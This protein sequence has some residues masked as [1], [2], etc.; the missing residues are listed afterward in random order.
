MSLL[1]PRFNHSNITCKWVGGR[2]FTG[3][4]PHDAVPGVEGDVLGLMTDLS[5]QSPFDGEVRG[6][7]ARGGAVAFN[8]VLSL[9]GDLE[10]VATCFGVHPTAGVGRAVVISVRG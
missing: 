9:D 4:E 8:A 7:V 3:G 6:D 10:D 1:L 5:S 2:I